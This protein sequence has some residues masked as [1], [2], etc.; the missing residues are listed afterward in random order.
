MTRQRRNNV[1]HCL[2][3]GFLIAG[4]GILVLA[5]AGFRFTGWNDPLARA[6][7]T[8]ATAWLHTQQQAD[9][10]FEV[11]GF[12]GFETPD[13]ILAI[14]EDA[15]RQSAWSTA[16]ALL[17]VQATKVAGHSALQAIDAFS[18]SGLNAGQA[19]KLIVLVAKP[20]GMPAW[21]FDP[22]HNGAVSLR[23]IV[24]AG[25]LHDGSYG[26][27]NATLYAVIALGL[28]GEPIGADTRAYIR[29]AQQPNGGWD[30]AASPTA[31]DA[32]VD[33]T[34]LAAQALVAARIPLA[35]PELRNALA[36]LARAQQSSGAWQSF[37]SDDPNS[38]AV[39]LLAVTAAGYDPAKPCWRDRS[40][41]ALRNLPYRSPVSW[42]RAQQRSDGRITSPNDPF[43]VTTF[44][45][46][47]AVTALRRGWLPIN[48]LA[49]AC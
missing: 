20:L 22:A 7:A 3:K 9:G 42:L 15:Q 48:P 8:K 14:A 18:Q 2:R 1:Q 32:D 41:P 6:A 37:G 19:A 45:T 35:N 36:F 4:T 12:A 28:L 40:V 49:K 16:Q 27:F 46:S 43:G 31:G 44:A 39:S 24:K 25:K 26:A 47:Q 38:T 30:Y 29:A 5:L 33:T 13:A 23:A 17:A 11:A 21:R 10:G 34:A